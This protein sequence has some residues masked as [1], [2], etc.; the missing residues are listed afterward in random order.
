MQS[1]QAMSQVGI[2]SLNSGHIGLANN[3]VSIWNIDRID[4][5]T[6]GHIEKTVPQPNYRP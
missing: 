6:I 2:L 5:E 4:L 3:L 1:S